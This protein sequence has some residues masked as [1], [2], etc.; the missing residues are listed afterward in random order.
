MPGTQNPF[1]PTFGRT[2]PELIDRDGT[3]EEFEY[4]LHIRSGVLGLLS[5]ITGARG[6]GKTV[7]L[8]EAQDL[9]R[10]QGWAVISETS[11]EGFLARIADAALL[12]DQ[13]LGDGPPARKVV[14]FT[15]G[16]FGLGT[17]L[18]RERQVE[19]RNLGARLL[20]R[21]DAHGTGLLIT[22]DEIQDANRGELL[23]LAA[24]LQHWVREG[25]PVG[26][27]CAGLPAA[28]SDIL[29]EGVA[30]FLRRADRID[31]HSVAIRDVH[32]SYARQFSK[33]GISLPEGFLEEAA[34][35]TLGYPFLVQL[36]GY[37]LWKEAERGAGV[38]DLASARRAV[39]IALKRNVRMVVGPA[40]AKVSERDMDYLRA[41]SVDPG[42]SSTAMVAE[43]MKA[44]LQ[45][46][47]NYRA[48][49]IEAGLIETA[50][51]GEVTY[52][53]PGLREHLR[54]GA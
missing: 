31:L 46:A 53:I 17:Q 25:L 4:G 18:P 24:V 26:F 32:D 47:S 49:L 8:N 43:R 33:A 42:P 12:I 37:F 28:V 35:S 41:M 27:V 30:T 23:Q 52:S 22:L 1:R 34:T 45:L 15:A 11:T 40:I 3:L 48:R 29:D 16:G 13:E 36:V 20:Q 5:I 19:F 44:S 21:L 7:M 2:P 10:E 51:R 14:S 6:V 50:G 54:G 38:V 39:A 9:A